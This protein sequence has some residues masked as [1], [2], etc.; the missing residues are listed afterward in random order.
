MRDLI[1]LLKRRSGLL[2]KSIS[3][4]EKNATNDA[5]GHLLIST[6]GKRAD[7]YHVRNPQDRHGKY[8]HDGDIA[9]AKALATKDYS[10][11]VLRKLEREKRLLDRYI[12]LLEAGTAEDVFSKMCAARRELVT[13][14]L[15]SDEVRAKMWEEETFTQSTYKPEMKIYPTKKGDLVR[16]KSEVFFADMYLEMG[17]PYRYEEVIALEDGQLEAPDFS[18]WDR[19]RRR[20]IYHEHFGLMDDPV[21]RK[22]NLKKVD[23]YRRSGI[24]TGKNLILTF[25]GD[26]AVLNM[27]EMRAMIEKIMR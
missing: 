25:E 4:A 10:L 26:G 7:F 2:G 15:V 14:V 3:Q 23:D 21:Y 9:L 16:S 20:V 18:L 5:E 11:K 24:F 12:R 6:R 22:R 27:K 19:K 1:D 8:I 17:I 13:P